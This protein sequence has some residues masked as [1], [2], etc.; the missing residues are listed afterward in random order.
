MIPDRLPNYLRGARKALGL[1]Q[2]ELAFLLGAET[3][4]NVTR[5]EHFLRT[6][7]LPTALALEAILDMPVRELFA[8]LF[9]EA[10]GASAA[11]AKKLLIF[12]EGLQ[13]NRH[14][15]VKQAFLDSLAGKVPMNS[16]SIYEPRR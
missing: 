15:S 1:S 12:M 3:A 7:T 5:Y 9:A 16:N 14:S 2:K 10:E 13:S 8:G 4:S 11:Q 6:P